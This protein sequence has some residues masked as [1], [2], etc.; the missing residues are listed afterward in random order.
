MDKIYNILLDN[1]QIGS[2]GFENSDPPRGVVFG[3]IFF[4]EDTFNYSFFKNYCIQNNIP[5]EDDI[6]V[7][8]IATGNIANLQIFDSEGLEIKGIAATISGMDSDEYLISI[9]GISYPFYEQEFS[10]HFKSYQQKF[11]KH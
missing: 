2:T 1:T 4:I 8:L 7:K 10:H 11:G 5:F 6:D 3:R 9:E